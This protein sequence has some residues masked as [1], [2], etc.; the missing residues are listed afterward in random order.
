MLIVNPGSS[1]LALKGRLYTCDAPGCK[2]EARVDVHEKHVAAAHGWID[3]SASIIGLYEP[4]PDHHMPAPVH[5]AS[6]IH[7][8]SRECAKKLL[9]VFMEQLP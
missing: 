9:R 7:A 1:Q 6:G 2:R 3:V 8:C 5:G 4:D